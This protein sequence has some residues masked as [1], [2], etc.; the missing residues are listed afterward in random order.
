MTGRYQPAR[1]YEFTVEA[2]DYETIKFHA[3]PKDQLP[4]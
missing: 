3:R 1:D 2:G 4:L